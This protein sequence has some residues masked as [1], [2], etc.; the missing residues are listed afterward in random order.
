MSQVPVRQRSRRG[1]GRGQQALAV[2]EPGGPEPRE[3][4]TQAPHRR[5]KAGG[6]VA[7]RRDAVE[8]GR[9]RSGSQTGTRDAHGFRGRGV[10]RNRPANG[11]DVPQPVRQEPPIAPLLQVPE[12]G[13]H[14]IIGAQRSLGQR[15][16]QARRGVEPLAEPCTGAGAIECPAGLRPGSRQQQGPAE[17]QTRQGLEGAMPAGGQANRPSPVQDRGAEMPLG[18]QGV[19]ASHARPAL[20]RGV[21][22]QPDEA[23]RLRCG[24]LGPGGVARCQAQVRGQKPVLRQGARIQGR[25]PVLFRRT[26]DRF[27]HAPEVSVG[28]LDH[29]PPRRGGH[30]PR[31]GDLAEQLRCALQIDA[32]LVPAAQI[33][34]EV[35]T[36]VVGLRLHI[37]AR[38]GRGHRDSP[39][40]DAERLGEPPLVSQ[41]AG[42]HGEASRD[43]R[44][45]GGVLVEAVSLG[46]LPPR[47]DG[48]LLLPRNEGQGLSGAGAGQGQRRL[49]GAPLGLGA[50]GPRAT[51]EPEGASARQAK[52]G[53][54]VR[55]G[56]V[57]PQGSSRD[58]RRLGEPKEP[59]ERLALDQRGLVSVGRLAPPAGA[60]DGRERFAM[61]ARGQTREGG[62]PVQA[63]LPW[64]G[65]R[66]RPCSH[67]PSFVECRGR[68]SR[69]RGTS[70]GLDL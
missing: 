25:A 41:Q 6:P 1:T 22:G 53:A 27:L 57:A 51:Q 18:Q 39:R 5:P 43:P 40:V 14:S 50:T 38:R 42:L 28:E 30:G 23:E 67:R 59:E 36:I 49:P 66:R 44:V 29:R 64:V 15:R 11:V 69:A 45:R 61:A 32:R 70:A 35:P 48:P 12:R 9:N 8:G 20:P 68:E 3:R 65:R 52:A 47:F 2:A 60:P 33:R 4:G 19:D 56:V 10:H 17:G 58:G 7:L 24:L 16:P 46:Q 62:L 63:R 54:R 21:P 34:E 13:L 31:A 26:F 37:Q 55:I